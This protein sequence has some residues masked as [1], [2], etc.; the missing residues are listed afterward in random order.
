MAAIVLVLL[1]RPAIAVNELVP[2]ANIIA[3]LVDDSRSMGIV[4]DGSTRLQQ[5][6]RALQGPWLATLG[7]TFQVREY[8]FDSGLARLDGPPAALTA[9]G[10]ATHIDAVLK[11]FASDTASVPVGALVLLTDG[12]D[13]GGRIGRDTIEALRQR[14]IPVH[15]VGFG[16]E[17]VARD[18]EL[19][20][21]A[22]TGRALAHSRVTA[23]LQVA[24][25]GFGHRR[26]SVTVR[27]ADRLL[28]SRELVLGEDGTTD[29]VEL[30]VRPARR[31]S[32][33]AA[34]PG[35]ATAGGEQH[36][37]QRTGAPGERGSRTAAHPVRG[38]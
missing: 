35:D 38:G 17:R 4:E 9:T 16:A 37:E 10:P 7:R 23:V 36:A 33:A 8:R 3:V 24:Q 34:L 20:S 30:Y 5:A 12:G 21:V 14:H 25:S 15:T 18:V 32:A 31:R 22:L 6:R 28:A 2:Q 13:N 19:E 27:D 26:T 1:W 11:Q 29:S